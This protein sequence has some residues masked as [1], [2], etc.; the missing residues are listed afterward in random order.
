MAQQKPSI[1][2]PN[3]QPVFK[4]KQNRLKSHFT[5]PLPWDPPK[6]QRVL[7]IA[8][9]CDLGNIHLT[10]AFFQA[11]EQFSH[12]F[13]HPE[14]DVQPTDDETCMTQNDGFGISVTLGK[15]WLSFS[16]KKRYDYCVIYVYLVTNLGCNSLSLSRDD[17]CFRYKKSSKLGD[18]RPGSIREYRLQS[19]LFSSRY[20]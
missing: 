3:L 10:V 18:F 16:I 14:K 7:L 5:P 17:A 9:E 13:H 11:R 19:P 20:P 15:Q 2:P 6:T 12:N 4:K 8:V 1:S